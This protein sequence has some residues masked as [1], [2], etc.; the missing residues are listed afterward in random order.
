M[1]RS[2]LE[3][4]GHNPRGIVMTPTCL[5]ALLAGG[6]VALSLTSAIAQEDAHEDA[7]QN[8]EP[9]RCV[10]MSSVRSTQVLDD[11]RVL[12]HQ[13]RGRAFLNRLD[14]DCI[15]LAR[16]G[17]FTY[18]VQSGARH[19]RLCATDSITVIET[20]GRGLNCGLGMFEPLSTEELE[21]LLAGPNRAITTTQ[22]ELPEQDDAAAEPAPSP[23]PEPEPSPPQ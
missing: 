8:S 23:A 10:S 13:A 21:S 12:F 14:R 4:S 22:V 15:G 16:S 19:A 7:G 6:A 9:V 20:I 1:S 18:Q 5:V 2:T 17:Q 11:R 3:S